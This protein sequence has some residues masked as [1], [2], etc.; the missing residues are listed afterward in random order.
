MTTMGAAIAAGQ[1]A[2]MGSACAGPGA[3]S[4][5]TKSHAHSGKNRHDTLRAAVADCIA[6]GEACLAH[7]I[8]ALGQ[9]DT[10]LGACAA[11]VHDMLAICR[12][13]GS[14]AAVNSSLLPKLATLCVDSC[15]RCEKECEPHVSHHSECKACFD[16]CRVV[17]AE[18]RKVAA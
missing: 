8:E 14:L 2:A 1:F 3:A 17:V 6:A 15:Q 10:S 7:C 16:A 12:A 13:M 5:P 9:G 4:Q 11:A 18:A